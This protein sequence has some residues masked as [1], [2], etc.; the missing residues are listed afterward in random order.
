MYKECESEQTGVNFLSLVLFFGEFS[1]FF[2]CTCRSMLCVHMCK[3]SVFWLQV[4]MVFKHASNFIYN[5]VQYL[6]AAIA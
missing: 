3:Y 1:E 5:L 2:A 4:I 6:S